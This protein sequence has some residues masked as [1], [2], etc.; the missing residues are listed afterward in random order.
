M[1]ATVVQCNACKGRGVVICRVCFHQYN[2]DPYD[3]DAIRELMSR[4]SPD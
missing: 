2:E 3:I 1:G 4:K